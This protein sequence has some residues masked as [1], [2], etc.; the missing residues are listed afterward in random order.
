MKCYNRTCKE[1][2]KFDS[3]KIDIINMCKMAITEPWNEESLGSAENFKLIRDQSIDLGYGAT[4][5]SGDLGLN[6]EE[7]APEANDLPAVWDLVIA[8][9]RARDQIGEARYATRLQPFNGRDVLVDAY[10]E[11]LDLAVYLR[12]AIYE[13]DQK[14]CSNCFL[15]STDKTNYNHCPDC[16]SRLKEIS[17]E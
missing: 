5:H 3:C 4:E 9:M 16:G 8:N 14:Q 11:A 10:Q 6:A 12:Q 13:R 15:W 17:N 1:H 2:G 7:P